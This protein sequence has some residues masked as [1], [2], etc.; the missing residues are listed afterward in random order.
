MNF[1]AQNLTDIIFQ[2]SETHGASF[3]EFRYLQKFISRAEGLEEIH[4]FQ[5][6]G[7]LQNLISR[8]QRRTEIN[9]QGSGIHKNWLPELTYRNDG[10][11]LGDLQK[12]ISRA[13]KLRNLQKWFS[14]AWGLTGPS[15]HSKNQ[16][17]IIHEHDNEAWWW[18]LTTN[19]D[20]WGMR[21]IFPPPAGCLSLVIHIGWQIL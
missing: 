15:Y 11:G 13:Q 16:F 2:D 4:T 1:R 6:P 9:L 5:S 20:N 14:R 8:A 10:P 7:A 3:P 18:S 21:I 17:R 19:R 12:L